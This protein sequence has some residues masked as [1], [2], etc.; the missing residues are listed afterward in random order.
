MPAVSTLSILAR[1]ITNPIK[2]KEGGE[3]S[4]ILNK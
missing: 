2:E 1:K 3:E 4:Q